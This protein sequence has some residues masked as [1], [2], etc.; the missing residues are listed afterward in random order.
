MKPRDPDVPFAEYLRVVCAK[1]P[2]DLIV[3]IGA[4]SIL[5]RCYNTKANLS[6]RN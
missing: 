4:G 1:E 5:S 6:V 3:S 2:L